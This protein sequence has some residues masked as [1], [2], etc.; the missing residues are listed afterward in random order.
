MV[1]KLSLA[2]LAVAVAAAGG[3]Y[4]LVN[5]EVASQVDTMIAQA[6]EGGAYEEISY[7]SV[8]MALDGDIRLKDLRVRDLQQQEYIV[9][10]LIVSD[11]DTAHE[12]PWFVNLQARG[13]RFTGELPYI[14]ADRAPA[15]HAYIDS[16]RE[17]ETL[18]LVV[19][20][21]YR[22]TPEDGS[23]LESDF[24]FSLEKAVSGSFSSTLR[25]VPLEQFF[26]GGADPALARM[27]LLS[28]LSAADIPHAR[29]VLEDRGA[30]QAM[31]DAN[32]AEANVPPEEFRARLISQAH[33]LHLFV[34]P[35]VEEPAR[36][37][38]EQLGRFLEGGRTLE[39]SL[40]PAFGGDM[41][42]LQPELFAAFFSQD[43]ARMVE[44]LNLRIMA[45]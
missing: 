15:L 20:Y 36:Q 4:F 19:D 40:D 26:A 28:S 21:R 33:N 27:R 39:I 9:E 34:P 24:G 3:A 5:R 13:F 29:L 18:P 35:Q 23:L 12:I 41:R 1:K 14:D 6:M 10:E 2:L 44:L 45:R 30:V 31:M 17:G 16:L 43:Y 38:G 25:N 42:Q 8:N 11:Y 7:G 37:A 32:A 22:Y